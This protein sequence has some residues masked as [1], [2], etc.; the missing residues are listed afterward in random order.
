MPPV[1]GL[2]GRQAEL[3][4]L[5]RVLTEG[6]QRAV[7][8]SGEPGVGKTALIE[9]MCAC[10]PLVDWRV[11]RVLGVQAEEPFAL[12]GLH[13]MVFG[14]K[15]FQSGLDERDRAVLEPVFGADPAAQV[16]VL[17][18]AA[19]LLSLVTVAARTRP[20]LLVVDDVHWLDRV[21]AEVL[22]AVGRRLTDPR[23][24]IVAGRR[25]PYESAF[26]GAG[27]AEVPLA[28]LGAED[29]VRLLKRAGV[30]LTE[31]T[32]AALLAAAAGNPLALAE[33]PRFAG[34]IEYGS[35]SIPLT[36]RLVAV[37]GGRLE[38]LEAD[39]R[40][41]L[42]RAAL[43]GTPVAAP[44]LNRPRY[45]MHNVEAAI[46]AGTVVA[47]P[48][49][50]FVFRHP[51][52]RAAVVHQASPSE[53]RDAHRD[54][55]ALY[56][57]VLMHRAYH[58][59]AAAAGPDQ[60]V[61][62]LLARAA[63]LSGRRGG[64]AVAVEWL[65]RAAALST[66][67]ARR[68]AYLADAIFIA[69]RAGRL[70]ETQDLLDSTR[71][72]FDE[73]AAAVLADCYRAFHADGDVASTHRRLLSTLAG[74]DTLDDG[75]VNQLVNLL[76]SVTGFSGDSRYRDQTNIAL[77]AVEKRVNPAILLYRAGVEDIVGTARAARRVL[78]GSVE[79]LPQ[80]PA[81]WVM[82]LSFPAYCIDAMADFRAP[83]A[84]AFAEVSSRGASIDAIEGG[85][86]LLIDLVAAGQWARAEEVGATCL[87]M[88][89]QNRG[90]ELVRHQLLADLG[91][92]AANR[93]DVETAR[94]YAGEVTAW[95]G[96]R[97]LDLHLALTRRIAV[98]VA[99]AEVDYEAAYQAATLVNPAG[100]FPSHIIAVA[101]DMLD[102][103]EAALLSGHREQARAHA[104]EAVHLNLAEVS[105]RVAALTLAISAM[106]APDAEAGELFQSAVN[107]PGI[108]EFPFDHARIL[109]AQGM[110]L[111]RGLRHTDARAVLQ[112]AA[113]GFDRLGARPWADRTR[114]ELRAAG[115]SFRQ[116]LGDTVALSAQEYR[117]AELAAAGRTSKE[118]A[119]QLSLSPRTV[120]SHLAGAFRK[121]GVTRRAG[122]GNALRDVEPLEI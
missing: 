74:A 32:A 65:R 1:T 76:L 96:P 118:I 45:V 61:A 12:G 56:Q 114:A 70:D 36:D 85:R 34:R 84:R 28:A 93:G 4:H 15:E 108:A 110:W 16:N 80:L 26:S 30:P 55:A 37:F 105:P 35:A 10:A 121:L 67:S 83:L 29:A 72:G 50:Q 78:E 31:A 59:A 88:A 5:I 71:G 63:Q 98:R 75:M 115:A 109:L 60:E 68:S 99:L 92:L 17:P 40:A 77:L 24:A 116:S 11:A 22:S 47:D 53:R 62:D 106:T 79:F 107:H 13:Q 87:E 120:D 97:G 103:V 42:L 117:V 6:T 9:H 25:A 69:A 104:E 73:S 90:S 23:V 82:L 48:L 3:S 113:D 44:S 86:V 89:R 7:V 64:L 57:D 94:R 102:L 38:Q 111:R 2:V 122:L 20:V 43:D 49:G 81:R 95:A 41:E 91:V 51:L 18:L 100:H 14:L 52:V 101:E 33:L 119:V 21:S 27:W 46:K 8:V 66:D 58:L 19:A 54:L 112:V 39:V